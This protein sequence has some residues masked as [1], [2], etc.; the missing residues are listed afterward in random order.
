[1]NT[2]IL[3]DTE[4]GDL[5]L[6]KGQMSLGDCR[7]QTAELLLRAEE[8]EIKE[9]PKLGLG[10]QR[11]LGASNSIGS[12]SVGASTLGAFCIRAKKQL[13]HCKIAVSRIEFKDNQLCIKYG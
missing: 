1:M 7:P 3:L 9:Y 13:K 8:G 6:S 11:L 4:T 10:I 5:D 12:M 2:G